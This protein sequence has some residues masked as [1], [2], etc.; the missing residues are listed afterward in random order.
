MITVRLKVVGRADQIQHWKQIYHL[1]S[2]EVVVFVKHMI[3]VRDPYIL[4]FISSIAIWLQY[5]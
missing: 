2:G 5:N 4:S 3:N 1:Y